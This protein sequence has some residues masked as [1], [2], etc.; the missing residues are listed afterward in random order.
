MSRYVKPALGAIA[1]VFA[2]LCVSAAE[3]PEP[4]TPVSFT[5]CPVARDMGPEADLC[6][7]FEHEGVKYG[8]V[9]PRFFGSPQLLHRVLV[10]GKVKEG[11]LLCGGIPVE[12]IASVM[13]EIDANCNT[14]I[15]F[16]GKLVGRTGGVFFS[17]SPQQRA[18]AEDLTRRVKENP[19]VSVTPAVYVPPP[20]PPPQP[21]FERQEL[22]I[23]F[24]YASDR[25]PGN[26]MRELIRLAEY[27]VAA[28]AKRVSV[29]GYAAS[30]LT[31]NAG[32]IDEDPAL[33]RIRAEKVASVLIGL[34]VPRD[35]VDV[36]WEPNLVEGKG[37]DDW[38]NR[39]V[40]VVLEP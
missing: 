4:G 18:L 25:G 38:R 30:S 14:L 1:S 9:N 34:G 16:D 23:T 13:P 28:R 26:S 11:P 5:A 21:P 10:E 15:P 36:K 12:G 33:A 6:F 27:A 19:R 22:V 32:R 40:H 24:A 29:V 35:V 3:P 20:P 7:Y 8:L 31:S 17:G 39:K 37:V 2:S